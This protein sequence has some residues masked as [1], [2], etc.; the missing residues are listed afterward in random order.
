MVLSLLVVVRPG[1]EQAEEMKRV[2]ASSDCDGSRLMG[3]NPLL[4]SPNPSQKA[5]TALLCFFFFLLG[6]GFW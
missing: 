6:L 1:P 3:E 4:S 2:I 5:K